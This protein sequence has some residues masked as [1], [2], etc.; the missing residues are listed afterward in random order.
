MHSAGRSAAASGAGDAASAP[1]PSAPAP[2]T[3]VAY[4]A[5]D[6]IQDIDRRLSALQDF[7]KA[8]KAS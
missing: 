2:V 1:A 4:D 8:A 3:N 5:T 7:L 6:D